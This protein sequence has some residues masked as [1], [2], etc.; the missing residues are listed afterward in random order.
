[1]D[2]LYASLTLG[3]VPLGEEEEVDLRPRP[4]H[5]KP[6]PEIVKL[7]SEGTDLSVASLAREAHRLEIKHTT[8]PDSPKPPS[9]TEPPSSSTSITIK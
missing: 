1:M 5:S 8:P 9:S 6:S 3:P 7:T 2:E 4:Q